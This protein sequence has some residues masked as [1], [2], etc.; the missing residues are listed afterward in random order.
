[1]EERAEGATRPE[2][3]DVRVRR[4]FER[5]FA[6]GEVVFDEAEPGETL[7]VIQAGEVELT[8]GGDAR[9]GVTRLGPGEFFG[10]MSVLVGAARA[11]RATAL[12]AARLLELDAAT[13][14]ELCIEKPEVAVRLLRR[15]AARCAELE[16]RLAALGADDVL[17]ALVRALVRRVE[18]GPDGLRV[19][20]NLV[21]LAAQSGISALEAWRGVQQLLDRRLVR[22]ADDVL[23]IPDLEALAACADPSRS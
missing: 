16:A 12:G 23:R 8:R 5:S 19:P 22:L 17:Q 6:A 14:E 9:R 21:A 11:E 20:G 1:V 2:T 7:F 10:E 18:A 4:S 3:T 15:L 13:L